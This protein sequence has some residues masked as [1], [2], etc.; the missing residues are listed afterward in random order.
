MLMRVELQERHL[1][2][3]RAIVGDASIQEILDLA[4]QL[5]GAR[6]VHVNA[7]AFGGGVAEILQS[8][9]PLMV[10]VGLRAE[11]RLIAGEDEFFNVTKSF[12]N[13]LQGMDLRLTPE[14]KSVW[15]RYNLSNANAFDG[16][17]DFVVVHD[18]QP[19][20]L[21][22]YHRDGAGGHWIWRSHIDTSHP[23][24]EYWEFMIPFLRQYRAAVFSLDQYVGAGL[25]FPDLAVIHP[26][27]DPLTP[28]NRPMGQDQV[29]Q[30]LRGLGL[31]LDR[32]VISQVSRYDPWKDP[33]GVIDAYRIVKEELPGVQ[34]A[35]MA[36]M[37]SDDPEG[38]EYLELTKR[39]VRND[40]DI[41]LLY[42]QRNNDLEV[43]ALQRG[44]DVVMQ[45]SVREGFG[46]VVT[47]AMWKAQ[48]VVGGDVGGIPLQ[49]TDGQTG[50]LVRS[51]EEC[52][53]R[54]IYLLRH[55]EEAAK[56]GE[57]AR[58]HVRRNFLVPRHLK[59]YL[60]LFTKLTSATQS[61]EVWK[62]VR[63]G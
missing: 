58:E 18:P 33:L 6:V 16:E 62:G 19:A 7:T 1:E 2:S 51:V 60:Q 3:Y 24:M 59:N 39:H 55:R 56:M 43:N 34:L 35:L 21:R 11:W 42:F 22:Y 12:H 5:K 8:L 29:E 45:K 28:K 44:S 49:I 38:W 52:A 14:M 25:E 30:I 54:V 37:A 26:S 27:I 23:N 20:G 48:A 17:Y 9:V 40:Q 41:Y 15:E 31:D 53:E 46:L 10:D 13:G 57:R 50:F 47:E 63:D 4:D 32:P 61:E 36:S